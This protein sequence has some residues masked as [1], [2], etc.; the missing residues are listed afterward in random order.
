[1]SK[2]NAI[3]IINL[4]YNNN[5]IKVSDE[6]F[7]LDGEA[8]L[9][10][11]RNGGGK[12]VLIQ[13]ITAL[14]VHKKYRNTRVRPF[15]SYFTTNKPTFIMVEWKLDGGA[16]FVLTGMMVRKRQQA[17]EEDEA[18]EEKLELCHFI[19]E[20]RESCS[21]DID[22]IA[23]VERNEKEIILKNY[24]AC[25]KLF[26]GYKK[27][28][29]CQFQYY[30]MT[31][32]AQSRAYF[33]KLLE[34]RI[35]SREW[36]SIIYEVNKKESGLSE[37]F[38][39]CRDEK[40]LV[41]KWFLKAAGDKLNQ[42]NDRIKGFQGLIEKYAGVYKKNRSKMEKRDTMRAFKEEAMEVEACAQA[43]QRA[44]E[45]KREQENAIAN[46]FWLLQQL[47]REAKVC[48]NEVQNQIKQLEEEIR[49]T[50]YEKLSFEFYAVKEEERFHISNRDM[51]GLEKED[52]TR[53]QEQVRS[54][55]HR[56]QCAYQQAEADEYRQEY[57]VSRQRLEYSRQKE[58]DMEPERQR[59]GQ[60]LKG[61]F[62]G[63]LEICKRDQERKEQKSQ[64]YR[65]DLEEKIRQQEEVTDRLIGRQGEI[66]RIQAKLEQYD[67]KEKEY[68]QRFGENLVR[69]IL[70]EYEPAEL[71]IRKKEA[72]EEAQKAQNQHQ[73]HKREL[74]HR[75]EKQNHLRR[76][77]EELQ[78]GIHEKQLEKSQ[79]EQEITG[80]EQELEERRRLLGYFDLTESELYDTARILEQAEKKLQAVEQA[81]L[82][83]ER[84]IYELQKEYNQISQGRMLELP[85]EFDDMLKGLGLH[86][87]Y[88]MDW[89]KKNGNSV[90]ENQQLVK[91]HPFLPYALILT[92]QE[93]GRLKEY[94][95]QI[96][97]SFPIPIVIREQL[98]GRDEEGSLIT[99]S[100]VSF[101]VYF[102]SSLLDEQKLSALLKE[103][104][105]QQNRK[106]EQLGRRKQEFREY[107]EKKDI[108]QR[109]KVTK[110][111]YEKRTNKREQLEQEIQKY[112]T[113]V[114]DAKEEY[115][116][117]EQELKTM[118]H[119][120]QK[121][122][123]QI[124]CLVEK[125]QAFLALCQA[126]EEYQTFRQEQ[127]QLEM[128][129]TAL[130]QQ[131]KLARE[132]AER[133]QGSLQTL[134]NEIAG[135]QASEERIRE[136]CGIYHSFSEE[137]P[138][139][140]GSML[141]VEELQKLEAKFQA[142]TRRISEENQEL[143]QQL[144]QAEKRMKKAERKLADLAEKY[145]L[146][147]QDWQKVTYNRKEELHQE[148]AYEELE[149]KIHIKTTLWNEEDKK[150]LLAG[151]KMAAK[152]SEIQ[153]QCG[154]SEPVLRADIKE[155]DY[156]A[157]LNQQHF[158]KKQKT[159]EEQELLERIGI[160]NNS[161][162][163]LSEY[164][165][166][167][168][169][170]KIHY[171]EDYR[172][173]SAEELRRSQGI[174]LRDYRERQEQ[175]Q[176][177]RTEMEKTLRSMLLQ[178]QFQDKDYREPLEVM[179]GLDSAELV[180]EQLHTIVSSYDRQLIKLEIDI[181]L[182]EQ[183]KENIVEQLEEYVQ[184][185]HEQ[186][187]KIDAHS[188]IQVRGQRI[189]M[190]T[191]TLPSW[192]EN[193]ELYRVKI[194]DFVD[195]IVEK[196]VEFFDRNENPMNYISARLTTK[197][198][199]DS[200][201]GI[202][203]VQVRLYKIEEYREYVI[204][205]AD[206]AKN[207]GGE[208]FLS[209]FIVLASLLYYMRKDDTDLFADKNEGKVLIM[210]NPFAQTNAA[211]L[212]KPMMDMARQTNTQLICL[213]GLGGESIYNCFDNIYVLNLVDASLRSGMQYLRSERLSGKEETISVSHI[214]VGE[215]LGLEF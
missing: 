52:L 76:R 165:A 209:A 175:V 103:K 78:Q 91:Q 51:I 9:L 125:E 26:E 185:V 33:D 182:Q 143:E 101:F 120:L 136:K 186:L 82:L 20:Y 153:E 46:F 180:L 98:E 10:S 71:E 89:L 178:E 23:V 123:E 119:R 193:Q 66:G 132:A 107:C 190:L 161:L 65:Q 188:T 170:K 84:E 122:E 156:K 194:K 191:L 58:A 148:A 158:Q 127:A 159:K 72:A 70:G 44:D 121:E 106:Q 55:L 118:N 129:L 61:H 113:D 1:M 174:L 14:F 160:Y 68:N 108:I 138:K 196:G 4:N 130:E 92:R 215:Q 37:L 15:E 140:V 203:N 90:Q 112:R 116:S 67:E 59:I 48:R 100:T 19:S 177:C 3:R 99:F 141:S 45:E 83:L 54:I 12:S 53:E 176:I 167:E 150:V 85:Q 110:K 126:Y 200:I 57:E 69:N 79:I 86:P 135:L 21:Y 208:G 77:M 134:E 124:R 56:L 212:L 199:Y 30:D 80:F 2:I 154:K 145:R 147:R 207:S 74:E 195:E 102:N 197:N 198:L 13:M 6:A 128:D 11:L 163:A 169:Q 81:R 29:S 49:H 133:I 211:H 202:H 62:E 157:L 166:L 32:Y 189:K 172:E 28:R 142:L 8:T 27:E 94:Q 210:D 22:H 64:E 47:D 105:E 93:F 214:Q 117:V 187:G 18:E 192:K 213:S 31:N 181:S 34:Y 35:N 17:A 144:N 204:Q 164:E 39:D 184:S 114:L 168:I 5:A 50:Q 104:A 179:L 115:A 42:R 139:P 149:R 162:S 173:K 60:Q 171:T 111:E 40:G 96:Y 73:N 16:G 25:L 206:V 36:E 155:K 201:V 151:Q 38:S 183:E 24:S 131:R 43:C 95:A 63:M 152:Q 7:K 205:W 146:S 109:Q 97:T 41:E 88:G 137:N 87:V 75:K